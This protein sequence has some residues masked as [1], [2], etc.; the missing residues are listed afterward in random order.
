MNIDLKIAQLAAHGWF[1]T[2]KDKIYNK[3]TFDFYVDY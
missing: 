2:N 3:N 1:T